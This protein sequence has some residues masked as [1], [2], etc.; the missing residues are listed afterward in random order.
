MMRENENGELTFH[1]Q[2]DHSDNYD[3]SETYTRNR[4]GGSQIIVNDEDSSVLAQ[5][6]R[7]PDS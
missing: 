3:H 5:H 6:G 4:F 1:D 2:N 7:Y